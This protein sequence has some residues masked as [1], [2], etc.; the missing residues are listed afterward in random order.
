M[1][2]TP[3]LD[4]RVRQEEDRENNRNNVPAGEDEPAKTSRI[5][6]SFN[7]IHRLR[8]TVQKIRP[9]LT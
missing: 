5:S 2:I 4:V 7:S 3:R 8:Q 1:V 9:G 6:V